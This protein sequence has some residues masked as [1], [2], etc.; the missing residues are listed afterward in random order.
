MI[1]KWKNSPVSPPNSSAFLKT[2]K[3]YYLA[4]KTLLPICNSVEAPIYFLFVHSIESALK[5]YLNLDKP[6]KRHIHQVDLLFEECL[7]KGL[8]LR[9]SIINILR[10]LESENKVH[11]FRYFYFASTTRPTLDHLS[12]VVE[13]IMSTISDEVNKRSIK[14]DKAIVLKISIGKPVKK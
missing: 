1:D 13:E 10:T 9:S 14:N 7:K 6:T 4:A 3:E 2:A 5:A 12:E 11:G 8:P